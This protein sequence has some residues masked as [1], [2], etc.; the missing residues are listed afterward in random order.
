MYAYIIQYIN[1][2]LIKIVLLLKN[3][4]TNKFNATIK[5]NDK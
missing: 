5:K 3:N 1:K 2:H 4:T